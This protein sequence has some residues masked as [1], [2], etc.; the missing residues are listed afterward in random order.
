MRE[1]GASFLFTGEVLGQRPMSQRRSALRTIDEDSGLGGLILRPLSALHLDP[2]VPE[3]EGWVNR[4]QLL[5]IS[6]RTRK[7][8]MALADEA[9]I[10]DYPCPAGGC[11]LTDRAF[12]ARL[13]DYF[14]HTAKPSI[15]D[16]TLLKTGRHRRLQNGDKIVIARNEGEGRALTQM[17]KEDYHLLVPDFPG[18]TVILQGENVACAMAC[19]LRHT[20]K[21]VTGDATVHHSFMGRSEQIA[22]S[23][24]AAVSALASE[25]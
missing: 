21:P 20:T 5:D 3:R 22:V 17:A 8:Q 13:R 15:K 2:T 25:S 11:L 7:R 6:G 24:A 18:P 16:I 23:T 1:I 9:G 10:R 4:S 12:A 14:H 19:L